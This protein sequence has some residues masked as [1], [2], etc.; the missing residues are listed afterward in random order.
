MWPFELGYALSQRLDAADDACLMINN[1]GAVVRLTAQSSLLCP[2]HRS[3]LSLVHEF[4]LAHL[5]F[6]R[7]YSDGLGNHSISQRT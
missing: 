3:R 5:Q 7:R 4:A 1:N 2:K 6:G